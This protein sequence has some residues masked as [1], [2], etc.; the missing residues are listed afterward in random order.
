VPIIDAGKT[1]YIDFDV[2]ALIKEF[3]NIQAPEREIDC[4]LVGFK[5]DYASIIHMQ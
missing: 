1:K 5:P 3:K 4:Q 2:L